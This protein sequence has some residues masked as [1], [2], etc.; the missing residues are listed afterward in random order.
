MCLLCGHAQMA[1]E[2]S[3]KALI[4]LGGARPARTHDIATLLGAL[5]RER[6]DHLTAMFAD[7]T[8]GQ[9]SEWREAG[10]YEYSDWSLDRLVPHAYHM[11]RIS[12]AISRHAARGILVT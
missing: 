10:A 4:H 5:P 7:V 1:M 9:A 2:T 8:P 11:A 3:L 12:I 6:R